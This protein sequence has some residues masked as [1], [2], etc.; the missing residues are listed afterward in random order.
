[1]EIDVRPNNP[2]AGIVAILQNGGTL[3][4]P[5]PEAVVL[6]SAGKELK[7]ECIW[8]NPR[9]GYGIVFEP[10]TGS[11]PVWIY[12]R[13][14]SGIKNP[15]TDKSTFRP[16]L[17]LFTQTNRA[18]LPEARALAGESPSG[19]GARMGQVPMVADRANR[20]GS[21]D[22][23]VSYYTGWINAKKDGNYRFATISADGSTVLLDGQVVADWPG[24]HTIKGGEGGQK[25]GNIKLTKGLHRIQ[26]F[27]F[28]VGGKPQCQLVWR[29]PGLEGKELPATPMGDDW[30]QSGSVKVI[31]AESRTGAPLALFEK[32]A[33]SYTGYNS[34]WIDLYELSVPFADQYKDATFTWK[35]GGGLEATG[36]RITWV[37]PRVNDPPPVTL[38]VSTTRGNSSFTRLLYPDVLPPGAQVS[39]PE[40]RAGYQEALLNRIK[41]ARGHHAAEDW[42]KG[43][44]SMLPEMIEPREAKELLH[45]LF[46]KVPDSMAALPPEARR[47][48]QDIY[49][50][51]LWPEKEKAVAFLR[52]MASKE[53]DPVSKF[54]WQYKIADF[55]LYDLGDLKG[56]RQAISQIQVNTLLITPEDAALRLVQQGDLERIEGNSD[57]AI[58][59]YAEAQAQYRRATVQESS[60]MGNLMDR[61]GAA[62]KPKEAPKTGFVIGAATGSGADWRKRTVRETAFFTDVKNL[63][64]QDYVAEARQKLNEWQAEFPLG[65]MAGD[66]PVA[67]AMYYAVLGNYERSV[68]ILKT[69]RKQV[70]IS[71]DLPE[72]MQLEWDCLTMLQQIDP[73]KDLASDI[74]KRFPD[75]PLA[76]EAD[77]VLAGNLPPKLRPEDIV[78]RKDAP[79]KK[80]SKRFQ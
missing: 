25:G 48:L 2:A 42:T 30:V 55:L 68:R 28:S 61:P 31:N 24:L 33:V 21:S 62:S 36:P 73:F 79:K 60:K 16:G 6:D 41:G 37:V 51:Q 50:E 13:G 69:Y 5:V 17:L 70:D 52:D 57:K 34:E 7:S 19:K 76:K 77:D 46:T 20:Y 27:H 14:A 11:G 49:S 18:S 65:K 32:T 1:M 80:K 15:W 23:F 54:R 67:E 66:Y 63:L 59:I 72:A 8:N 10:P 3:P 64:A 44:W 9:E 78:A 40:D 47:K 4:Q 39:N 74:K 35:F 53:K 58:Q 38:A 56:A 29:Y 22:R 71:K 12:L 26:Y 45:E 43:M 75:L